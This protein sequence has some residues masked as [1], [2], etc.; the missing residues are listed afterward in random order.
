V[1]DHALAGLEPHRL[2]VEAYLDL[3][4]FKRDE[5]RHGADLGPRIQVGPRRLARVADVVIAAHSLVGAE[6]LE[7]HGGERGF[8]HVGPRDVPAR[9]EPRLKQR[10]R[11]ARVRDQLVA[12]PD[13]Q[14]AA[15]PADVDPV[16]RVGGVADDPVIFLVEG[17][18][19]PPAERDPFLQLARVVGQFGVLPGRPVL[20]PLPGPDGVPGGRPEVPVL[21]GVHGGRQHVG[22]YVAEGEVGDRVV[23][24]LVQQHDVLAVGNP[25][26][27]EPD[28]HP[29][30]ERFGEQQSLRQR[31]GDQKPADRA[32]RERSLLPSQT[33]FPVPFC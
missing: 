3:V 24:W 27:T 9:R 8:V 7:L 33:H 26:V 5:A 17:V 25:G 32:R 23:T 19:R 1:R 13:D 6:S 11:P 31:S 30:P 10:Q 4:R 28:P 22:K 20:A 18:H 16:V 12:V 29:P 14:T 21:G 2:A 15:G